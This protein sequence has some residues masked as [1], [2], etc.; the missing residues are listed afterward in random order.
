MI[1]NNFHTA[2]FAKHIIVYFILEHKLLNRIA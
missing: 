2:T 1:D